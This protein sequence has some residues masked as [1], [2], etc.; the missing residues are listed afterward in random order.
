MERKALIQQFKT[1][2]SGKDFLVLLNALK[3]EDFGDK[4]YPFTGKHLKASRQA[5]NAKR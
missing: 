2:T 4:A 1:V 3:A 5:Q